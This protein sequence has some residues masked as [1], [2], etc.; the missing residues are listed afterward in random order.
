PARLFW[1]TAA[2]YLASPLFFAMTLVSYHDHL[3][4]FLC[5]A[6]GWCFLVFAEAFEAGERRLGWLYAGAVLLGLAVL[7]KYNAVLFGF[8]VALFFL[9]RSRLR[10]LLRDPHLWLTTLA[11]IAVQA[12]VFAWN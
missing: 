3:L 7:T 9:F 1:L 8:G 10:P 2:T 11:A 4:V 6:S 12:P 5:L